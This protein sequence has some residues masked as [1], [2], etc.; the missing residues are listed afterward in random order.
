MPT[1]EGAY[2]LLAHP[3]SRSDADRIAG[4]VKTVVGGDTVVEIIR[5]EEF[6]VEALP[7]ELQESRL[8]LLLR[9]TREMDLSDRESLIVSNAIFNIEDWLENG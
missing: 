3:L 1:R 2:E 8:Q 9:M 7:R 6:Q 5:R 4:L